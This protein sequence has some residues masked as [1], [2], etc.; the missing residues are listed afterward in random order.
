MGV[1]LF[2]KYQYDKEL[3]LF[4]INLCIISGMRLYI[5]WSRRKSHAAAPATANIIPKCLTWEDIS[6]NGGIHHF[7][8]TQRATTGD[9]LKSSKKFLRI[10][11]ALTIH[12]SVP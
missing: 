8:D 10:L 7:L 11:E 5:G 9:T 1:S 12:R 2:P 4:D 6:S 3:P